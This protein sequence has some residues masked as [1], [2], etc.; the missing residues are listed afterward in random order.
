M[1]LVT[2]DT[3]RPRPARPRFRLCMEDRAEDADEPL[4]RR[5]GRRGRG[6]V[7]AAAIDAFGHQARIVGHRGF[8]ADQFR[9]RAE[10]QP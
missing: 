7:A 4:R 9:L 6:P 5:R 2:V 8:V 3:A 1:I 10:D